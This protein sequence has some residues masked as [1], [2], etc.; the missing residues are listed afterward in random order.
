MNLAEIVVNVMQRDGMAVIVN[1]LAVTIRERVNRRMCIRMVR[2][3]RSTKDVLP[4][5]SRRTFM[6]MPSLATAAAL[7]AILLI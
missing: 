2:F 4:C 1:L 3:W 6:P 5:I 7:R